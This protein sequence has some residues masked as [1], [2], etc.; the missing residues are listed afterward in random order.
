MYT[1]IVTAVSSALIGVIWALVNLKYSKKVAR[2]E[3]MHRVNAYGVYLR[4]MADKMMKII[5]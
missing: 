1:G 5:K 3:E 4:K 2:E